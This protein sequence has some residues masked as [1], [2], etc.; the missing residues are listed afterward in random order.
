MP[1]TDRR[2]RFHVVCRACRTERVLRCPD[3]AES[4]ADAHASETGHSIVFD[5]VE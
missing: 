3:E 1:T 5:R 4:F 2:G